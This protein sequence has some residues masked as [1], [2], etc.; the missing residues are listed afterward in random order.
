MGDP[1]GCGFAF[2][3]PIRTPTHQA[4]QLWLNSSSTFRGWPKVS[5][6]DYQEV[7]RPHHSILCKHQPS[8]LI[9]LAIRLSDDIDVV[10]T[11]HC[12]FLQCRTDIIFLGP[13]PQNRWDSAACHKDLA[14][15]EPD[16]LIVQQNG[17]NYEFRSVRAERPIPKGNSG[18][19][20]YEVTIV[21]RE[22]FVS[23]GL[24]TKQK[25]LKDEW[26]GR[27]E[28][29]YA[30]QSDGT[31]WGHAVKGCSRSNGRPHIEGKL[32]FG[33]GDVIGCGVNL[34]TRQILH[35]KWTAF[36]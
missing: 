31:F 20:Y 34:A 12:G 28:G 10:R 27:Y 7:L 30:Y 15:S 5:E 24:A 23:I 9:M 2:D 6:K 17:E 36:G 13:T 18:I 11:D 19:F 22:D 25:P 8:S 3:P 26:V 21:K 33:V 4:A 35:K 16:Q 29:T 1:L 32:S 14:L